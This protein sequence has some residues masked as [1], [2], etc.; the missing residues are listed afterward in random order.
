M[1]SLVIISLLFAVQQI[2]RGL[3]PQLEQQRAINAKISGYGTGAAAMYDMVSPVP[4][5][6]ME[7][8]VVTARM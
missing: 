7:E 1:L 4:E 8:V 2:R 6:A 5:S 3:Y